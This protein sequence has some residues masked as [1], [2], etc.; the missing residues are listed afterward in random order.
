VVTELQVTT[1]EAIHRNTPSKWVCY[2]LNYGSAK[3]EDLGFP[4]LSASDIRTYSQG[5]TCQEAP[6]KQPRSFGKTK[7]AAAASS[8]SW[9]LLQ[10]SQTVASI[11]RTGQLL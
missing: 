3:H 6:P 11:E 5:L 7:I 8:A 10:L 2:S 9:P 4:L 1:H